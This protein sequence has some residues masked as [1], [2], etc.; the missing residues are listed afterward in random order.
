MTYP[1]TYYPKYFSND[2]FQPLYEEIKDKVQEYIV[3]VY[4]KDY[5][6]RRISCFFTDVKTENVKS[7][8]KYFSYG[9]LPSFNW[10]ESDIIYNIK[11]NIEEKLQTHFD[12]CLVHIYRNGDDMIAYHNDK[13]ALDTDIASVSF[14]ATRKFRMRNIGETKGYT[15]EFQLES[16][17]LFY[18][19]N[20][21]QRKYTHSVPQEKKVKLPRINLTFRKSQN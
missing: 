15:A 3:K 17:D 14:G 1:W 2:L 11:L 21:C 20:G 12:Y 7:K 10:T 8:S 16:G 13:E 9:N 19:H 18:M 5:P 6:S 4:G